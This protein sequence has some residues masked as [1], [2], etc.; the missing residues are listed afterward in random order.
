MTAALDPRRVRLT[1][2]IG[3]SAKSYEGLAITASGVKCASSA[4]NSADVKIL[5]LSKADRDHIL[6]EC[7][8]FNSNKERKR[9]TIEAGRESTGLALIFE[10]DITSSAAGQP[11]DPSIT[12]KS[13]TGAHQRGQMTSR[14]VKA[15]SHRGLAEQ[16]ADEMGVALDYSA[17]D[18]RISNYCHCGDRL[19]EVGK[20]GQAGGVRAYLDDGHLVVTD[21]N[22]ARH[23]LARVLDVDSGLVGVPEWTEHGVKVRYMLDATSRLGGQLVLRSKINPAVNGS[24]V[25]VKLGFEIASRDTPFYYIAECT[26]L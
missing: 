1:L 18:K 25:I 4:D 2:T 10:G 14:S 8:P 6:T 26:R 22:A 24:W 11:P 17:T 9:M 12:L 21:R 5:N 15:C 3:N 19:A 23:G 7:S 16:I 20:L 13:Q